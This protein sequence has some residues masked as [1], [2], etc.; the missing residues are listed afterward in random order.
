[1]KQPVGLKIH[2]YFKSYQSE[3]SGTTI[4]PSGFKRDSIGANSEIDQE[5]LDNPEMGAVLYKIN[6]D[7]KDITIMEWG[8]LEIAVKYDFPEEFKDMLDYYIGVRFPDP[9]WQPSLIY[10]IQN[11]GDEIIQTPSNKIETIWFYKKA[12]YINSNS[13]KARV[14]YWNS[15]E[16]E[17]KGRDPKDNEKKWIW[18][19]VINGKYLEQNFFYEIYF[20]IFYKDAENIEDK[21]VDNA[22]FILYYRLDNHIEQVQRL[23]TNVKIG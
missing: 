16:K 3:D 1:M 9:S 20:T 5:V 11:S 17:Y 2:T 14:W 15:S 6:K 18:V 12:E 8:A 7:G 4:S 13:E 19:P 10:N 21:I 22:S 23:K